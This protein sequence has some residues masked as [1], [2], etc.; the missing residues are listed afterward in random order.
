M[1]HAA[2]AP[3]VHIAHGCDR[4]TCFTLGQRLLLAKPTSALKA[5]LYSSQVSSAREQISEAWCRLTTA[6]NTDRLC[7]RHANGLRTWLACP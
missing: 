2:Q 6:R 4:R 1:R 5:A 3:Q 7:R